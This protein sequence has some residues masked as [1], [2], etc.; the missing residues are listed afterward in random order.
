MAQLKELYNKAFGLEPETEPSS[1]TNSDAMS[2]LIDVYDMVI[3]T[4]HSCLSC[5]MTVTD[6][7]KHTCLNRCEMFPFPHTRKTRKRDRAWIE[8]RENGEDRVSSD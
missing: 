2:S 4:D 7:E 8:H 5:Y 6:T 3:K 1:P